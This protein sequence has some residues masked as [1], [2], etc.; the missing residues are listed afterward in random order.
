MVVLME[1]D[2]FGFSWIESKT[3]HRGTDTSP[4]YRAYKRQVYPLLDVLCLSWQ[5]V[6][7]VERRLHKDGSG[8]HVGLRYVQCWSCKK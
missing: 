8:C 4:E 2:E 1:P 6:C 3:V 7:R 5:D